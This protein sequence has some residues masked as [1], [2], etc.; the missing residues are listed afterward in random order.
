MA[1]RERESEGKVS[2]EVSISLRSKEYPDLRVQRMKSQIRT[3]REA[4]LLERELLKECASELTRREGSEATWVELIDQWELAH[5]QDRAANK[6]MQA[7]TV[8]ETVAF[9]RRWTSA[10]H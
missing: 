9:L 10:W 2:F 4:Q 3:L 6:K 7:N 8:A 5:R 1:I